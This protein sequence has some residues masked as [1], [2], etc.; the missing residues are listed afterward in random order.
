MEISSKTIKGLLKS[1]DSFFF[2]S[3]HLHLLNELEEIKLNKTANFYIESIIENQQ[4]I[5]TYKI[6]EGWSDLKIGQLLFDNEGLN[7][8][9]K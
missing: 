1:K 6:K 5:F 2:I 9:L 8:L 7:D 4:P 3:T